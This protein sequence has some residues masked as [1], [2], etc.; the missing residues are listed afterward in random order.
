MYYMIHI[1]RNRIR[2]VTWI[3]VVQFINLV[4]KSFVL[5]KLSQEEANEENELEVLQQDNEMTLE[6]L[7]EKLPP[8]MLQAPSEGSINSVVSGDDKASDSGEGRLVYLPNNS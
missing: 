3:F 5:F 4:T 7:L 2:I 6:E 8:E 1:V